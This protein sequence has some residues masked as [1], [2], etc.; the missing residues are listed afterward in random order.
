M[1]WCG[2]HQHKLSLFTWATN[3][4]FIRG[5]FLFVCVFRKLQCQRW[6][7]AARAGREGNKKEKKNISSRQCECT[8]NKQIN[9]YHVIEAQMNVIQMYP[10]TNWGRFSLVQICYRLCRGRRGLS[11]ESYES[12]F[13]LKR[14]HL[15]SSVLLLPFVFALT[16]KLLGSGL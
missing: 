8:I 12:P 16:P 15:T 10:W 9:H 11:T 2:M 6:C 13:P 5:D 7:P 4:R 3:G 14:G 1:C